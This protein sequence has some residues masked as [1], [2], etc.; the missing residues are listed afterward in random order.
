MRILLYAENCSPRLA[1]SFAS[2]LPSGRGHPSQSTTFASGT[3]AR[4]MQ[5]HTIKQSLNPAQG[6]L[7]LLAT[8]ACPPF[9]WQRLHCLLG[10]LGGIAIWHKRF[11]ICVSLNRQSALLQRAVAKCSSAPLHSSITTCCTHSMTLNQ[12]CQHYG[13]SLARLMRWHLLQ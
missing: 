9:A 1:L 4:G 11:L 5:R 10:L 6:R 3:A 7:F 13:H 2:G 12:P 8:T